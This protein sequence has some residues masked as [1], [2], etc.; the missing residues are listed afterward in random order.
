MKHSCP[1]DIFFFFFSIRAFKYG[2]LKFLTTWHFEEGCSGVLLTSVRFSYYGF[3]TLDFMSY[4]D[5]NVFIP[6]NPVKNQRLN[7]HSPLLAPSCSWKFWIKSPFCSGSIF[8]VLLD[9]S[10]E[11]HPMRNFHFC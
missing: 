6:P 3:I 5:W 8:L 10:H 4:G 9:S 11:V 7:F 1:L 2:A